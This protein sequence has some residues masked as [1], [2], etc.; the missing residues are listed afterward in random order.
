MDLGVFGWIFIGLLAGSISGWFVG[1]RS[2]Q[3]CL[4][5]IVVGV[6]GGVIGG[7]LSGVMGLGRVE[8]LLGALVFATIGSILV[9]LV[10]RSI[11]GRA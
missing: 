1:S 11:E 4:P 2:V 9:R 10:L 7:W 6:I 8:G 5:T 3:G